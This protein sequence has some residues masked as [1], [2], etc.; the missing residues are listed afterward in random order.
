M[1]PSN[2]QIIWRHSLSFKPTSLPILLLNLLCIRNLDY[3]THMEKTAP[4]SLFPSLPLSMEKP[5][6]AVLWSRLKRC[7][8]HMKSEAL[9]H[10]TKSHLFRVA[11]S[12]TNS[13][14]MYIRKLL[15]EQT[16][17]RTSWGRILRRQDTA[18]Q[19]KEL[20][21]RGSQVVPHLLHRRSNLLLN[22]PSEQETTYSNLIN[23]IELN[24][25]L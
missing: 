14:K 16:T 20:R 19:A 24:F 18:L 15:I 25:N 23:E 12:R 5:K 8:G 10:S 21:Q 4:I 9:I 17:R 11:E 7:N 1:Y 13:L 3:L 6:S 2:W 22:N